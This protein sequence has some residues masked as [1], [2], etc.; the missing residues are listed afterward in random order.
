MFRIESS[1]GN[2]WTAD[3]IGDHNAFETRAEAERAI[4]ALRALGGDWAEGV[5]RIVED[6]PCQ[7]RPAGETDAE[8]AEC[9]QQTLML[10]LAEAL[11][12][13]LEQIE[14]DLDPGHQEA[15]EH[16]RAVLARA[17]GGAS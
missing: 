6:W 16:A 1:T 3:T 17:Q 9:D 8:N 7:A 15:L 5:Y 13:A 10:D 14:D 11:A 4:D 12:W 2:A